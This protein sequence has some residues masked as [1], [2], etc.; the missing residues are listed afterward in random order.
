MT[1]SKTSFVSAVFLIWLAHAST[2]NAES[3]LPLTVSTNTFTL[4]QMLGCVIRAQTYLEV[5]RVNLASGGTP[6][7]RSYQDL[8]L[9][10]GVDASALRTDLELALAAWSGP[11]YDPVAQAAMIVEVA[12]LEYGSPWGG[13]NNY[14]ES[15]GQM[16]A[17]GYKFHVHGIFDAYPA[18]L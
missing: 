6:L 2:V 13:A 11:S 16:A 7:P 8:D 10:I 17:C 15:W 12:R 4:G 14:S 5:S 18:H 3:R 1:N 9:V